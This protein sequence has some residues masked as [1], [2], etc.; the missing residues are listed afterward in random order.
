MFPKNSIT[1]FG[2]CLSLGLLAACSGKQEATES[3][4]TLGLLDSE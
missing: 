4:A 1:T 3:A 2:L